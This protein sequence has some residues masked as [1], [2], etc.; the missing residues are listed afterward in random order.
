MNKGEEYME[1]NTK[2]WGGDSRAV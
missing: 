2:R 1:Y